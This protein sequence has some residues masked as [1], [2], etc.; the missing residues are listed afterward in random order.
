MTALVLFGAGSGSL[1]AQLPLTVLLS[2]DHGRG[3]PGL[4][5]AVRPGRRGGAGGRRGRAAV[6][7]LQGG[8][9]WRVGRGR[10]AAAAGD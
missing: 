9:A 3:D 2:R 4:L 6:R 10:L 8:L 7:Q 1:G 5:R